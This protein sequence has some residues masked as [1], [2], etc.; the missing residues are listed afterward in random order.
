[1][2]LTVRY[3]CQFL[4][5]GTVAT[6]KDRPFDEDWLF[7]GAS[8]K[9]G[10]LLSIGAHLVEGL[11]R[12]Q[13]GERVTTQAQNVLRII[14]EVTP[15]EFVLQCRVVGIGIRAVTATIDIAMNGGQDSHRVTTIDI[16]RD[17]VTA[18]DIVD[19]TAE[20]SRT[21]C[22]TCRNTSRIL[23]QLDL[24][25]RH[26]IACS[27]QWTYI[28]LSATAVDIVDRKCRILRYLQQQTL[29]AGHTTLVTTAIEVS[30]LTAQ[31]VPPG[32]N[33]HVDFVVTT[34]EVSYLEGIA[35]RIG[36]LVVN[37]HQLETI[38]GQQVYFF[39][40]VVLHYDVVH[41]LAW[42]VQMNDNIL[43]HRSH[44]ATTENIDDRTA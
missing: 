23:L 37:T 42:I 36:E 13:T 9:E 20:D 5:R 34:E 3:F 15:E 21:G 16:S 40:F 12:L 17:I 33:G 32:L 11:C 2:G 28:G 43:G 14:I 7:F 19:V 4:Q 6:H 35:I 29:W 41:H 27:I 18:I 25:V 10:H 39:L 1:M 31:Q 8:E 30:H 38:F 26:I 22:K 44:V 24:C